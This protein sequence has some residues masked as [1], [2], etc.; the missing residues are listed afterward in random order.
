MTFAFASLIGW[1]KIAKEKIRTFILQINLLVTHICVLK[2]VR[3][4]TLSRGLLSIASEH[5]S[6]SRTT[7][8]DVNL[9]S[10]CFQKEN[11]AVEKRHHTRTAFCSQPRSCREV[12]GMLTEGST[13][14]RYCRP[15]TGFHWETRTL[16]WALIKLA[17]W[18]FHRTVNF[19][20]NFNC[21]QYS[22]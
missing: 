11:R 7:A 6:E 20:I 16:F 19:T 22:T 14:S 8:S 2:V 13:S 18:Q 1:M 17:Q 9:D 4:Q 5:C 15:E 10:L 12:I 21:S 3:R